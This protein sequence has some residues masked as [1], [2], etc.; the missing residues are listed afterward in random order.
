MPGSPRTAVCVLRVE[1]RGEDGILITITITPDVSLTSSCHS[2]SVVR[3]D[4]AL[5][6]VASFLKEYERHEDLGTQT[7]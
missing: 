4:D 5:A 7:P 6:L 1:P 3:S 2:R